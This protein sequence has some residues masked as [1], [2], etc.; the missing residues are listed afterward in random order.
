MCASVI[1]VPAGKLAS[2]AAKSMVPGP[3][4]A[5][6][7]PRGTLRVMEAIPRAFASA[8]V[9]G[10]TSLAAL[11]VAVKKIG[12][13]FGEGV[14]GVLLSLPHAASIRSAAARIARRV[15][16]L[17][18]EG[19][20]TFRSSYGSGGPAPLLLSIS[21]RSILYDAPPSDPSVADCV[22]RFRLV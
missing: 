2:C 15:I 9:T 22:K 16:V 7:P 17:F 5:P 6:L 11:I 13:V 8:L 1:G 14:V 20:L 12:P 10:G 18:S 19:S 21:I 4:T 3:V